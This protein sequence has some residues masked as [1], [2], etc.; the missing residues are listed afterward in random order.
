MK[1]LPVQTVTDRFI[2]TH[3]KTTMNEKCEYRSPSA[4]GCWICETGNGWEDDDMKFD[5]E[6]DTF[7]HPECLDE[8]NVDTV[9]EYE[10]K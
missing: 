7:V 8:E 3:E 4:G 1:V 10:R 6:F 5:L 9:L 2:G